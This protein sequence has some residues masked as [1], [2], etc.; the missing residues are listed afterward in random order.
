MSQDN[1]LIATIAKKHGVGSDAVATALTALR[2]GNGTMAQFSHADFGGMAQWSR[3]GMS[4]VGDMFNSGMKTRLDGV[5]TDLAAA[6]QSGTAERTPGSAQPPVSEATSFGSS[7]TGDEL[8]SDL[9][10]PSSSGSQNDMR[11]AFFP[12]KQRLV[13]EDG[14]KR[15]VYDTGSH[16]IS[17]VSQQQSSG[18]DLSFTSQHGMVRLAELKIID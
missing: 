7:R 12:D 4:M 8:R 11:Y 18:R 14:G 5:M 9:G 6:L 2:R 15:T 13:I 3:G 1:E 10:S 17:G 16:R